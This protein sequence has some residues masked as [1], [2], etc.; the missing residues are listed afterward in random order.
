ML[1]AP[2]DPEDDEPSLE[3][4][5]EHVELVYALLLRMVEH[6]ELKAEVAVEHL[7]VV[8][9]A[10]CKSVL[11]LVPLRWLAGRRASYTPPNFDT[12]PLCGGEV[13]APQPAASPPVFC[14]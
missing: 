13:C 6:K 9:S 8:R 10:L 5:W 3:P 1:K 2:Y 11:D 4:A 7:N 12:R 14:F